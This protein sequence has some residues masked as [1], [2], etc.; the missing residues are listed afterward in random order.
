MG[1]KLTGVQAVVDMALKDWARE[2][3]EQRDATGWSPDSILSRMIVQGATGAAQFGVPPP[4]MSDPST[5]VDKA[6]AKVVKAKTRKVLNLWYR[7]KND[8]EN[9][10]TCARLAGLSARNFKEHLNRGRKEV[11]SILGLAIEGVDFALSEWG[12]E[13][14]D[15]SP[16]AMV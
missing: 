6:V 11:A 10:T 1:R 5:A 8:G 3:R 2:S 12:D 15:V 13:C 9:Q 4:S 14:V 16:I 7:S